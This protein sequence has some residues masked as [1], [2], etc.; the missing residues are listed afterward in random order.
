M[1]MYHY[2]NNE[3]T[4]NVFNFGTGKLWDIK[5]VIEIIQRAMNLEHIEPLYEHQKNSEILHQYLST[6]KAKSALNWS[7]ETSLEEGIR[8]T[9]DWYHNY[10]NSD[11]QN[12]ESALN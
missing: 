10:W 4:G 7:A 2:V 12:Y 6:E 3:G 11:S 8:K 5:K 9:V 1:A